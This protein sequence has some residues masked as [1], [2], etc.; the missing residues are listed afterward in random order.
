MIITA[1]RLKHRGYESFDEWYKCIPACLIYE[2]WRR[3]KNNYPGGLAY[4]NASAGSG[5]YQIKT[6][7]NVIENI[8]T[9][10]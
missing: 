4:T 8:N 5:N 6:M 3:H 9:E 1:L 2:I 7:R 10:A